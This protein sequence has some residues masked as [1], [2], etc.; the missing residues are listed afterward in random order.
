MILNN[1]IFDTINDAGDWYLEKHFYQYVCDI[2]D[3]NYIFISANERIEVYFATDIND[4][5]NQ[6][7]GKYLTYN[8][9][10]EKVGDK[11]FKEID[12]KVKV[13]LK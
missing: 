9:L 2:K 3:S 5:N 11:H 4:L 13:E 10:F 7:E 6:I 12:F 8:F 1:Y